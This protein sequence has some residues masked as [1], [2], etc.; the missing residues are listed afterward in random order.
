MPENILTENDLIGLQYELECLNHEHL[1]DYPEFIKIFL[2]AG[3]TGRKLNAVSEIKLGER[4]S[5]HTM[6]DYEDLL[7]RINEHVRVQGIDLLRIFEIFC[8]KSGGFISYDDLKKC[9]ELLDFPISEK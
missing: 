5:T 6:N 3:Q 1:V 7:G 4:R 2:Q 9:I 8:K